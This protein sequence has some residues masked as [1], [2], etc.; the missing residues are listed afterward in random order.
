MTQNF[1]ERRQAFFIT[2]VVLHV[3]FPLK[4]SEFELQLS[5]D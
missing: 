4:L 5:Y 1:E 3:W 2:K